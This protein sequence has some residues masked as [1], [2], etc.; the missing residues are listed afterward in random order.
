[1]IHTHPYWWIGVTGVHSREPVLA[2]RAAIAFEIPLL[3]VSC[4]I[5]TRWYLGSE[6]PGDDGFNRLYDVA[7]LG[8]FLIETVLVTTLVNNKLRYLVENWVN[9]AIILLGIPLLLGFEVQVAAL[10]ILRILIVISVLIHLS[11]S[12]RKLLSYNQLGITL[13]ACFIVITL[14]GIVMSAIDPGIDSPADGIWWAWVT[15]SSVGYGDVVPTSAPGKLLGGLIILLGVGLIAALT[16][17][18]AAFLVT[19]SKEEKSLLTHEK[20][21]VRHIRKL[22][23]RLEI[24]EKKLDEFL[25]PASPTENENTRQQNDTE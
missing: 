10:R 21:E 11:G 4:W 16:A 1:L 23:E 17:N 7:L 24:I 22:E 9:I 5:L 15:V 6:Q 14:S 25:P 20:L 12:V 19:Q 18:V 3:A 2:K 8:L 13:L